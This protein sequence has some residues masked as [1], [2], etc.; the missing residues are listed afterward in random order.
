VQY[1]TMP[2]QMEDVRRVLL[3]WTLSYLLPPSSQKPVIL[4]SVTLFSI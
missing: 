4:N 3:S 1:I 2:L